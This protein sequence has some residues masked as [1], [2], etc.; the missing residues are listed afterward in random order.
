MI[1][2]IKKLFKKNKKKT[3][4]QRAYEFLQKHGSITIRDLAGYPYYFNAPHGVIRN[5]I[6]SGVK[7]DSTW[8]TYTQEIN[9]IKT[10]CRYKRYDLISNVVNGQLF[11]VKAV[12]RLA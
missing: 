12:G 8:M 1:N 6:K 11:D 4:E 10:K 3:Q 5:L 7:L 2:F 9:G